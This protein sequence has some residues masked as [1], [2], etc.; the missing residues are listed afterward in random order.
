MAWLPIARCIASSFA[1]F[2]SLLLM[3]ACMYCLLL[4][5]VLH[6]SLHVL[7]AIAALL[8]DTQLLAVVNLLL[9]VADLLL[10]IAE[11]AAH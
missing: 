2:C 3:H 7:L 9:A 6:C 8:A 1:Y 5:H 11:V 4:L 10:L